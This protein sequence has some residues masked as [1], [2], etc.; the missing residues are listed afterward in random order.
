MENDEFLI[1]S[2][3]KWLRRICLIM[4]CDHSLGAAA[5]TIIEKLRLSGSLS[6]KARIIADPFTKNSS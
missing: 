2:F 3:E 5:S 1:D 4:L 6:M